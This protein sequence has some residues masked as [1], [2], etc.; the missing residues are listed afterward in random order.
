MSAHSFRMSVRFLS[1]W[2]IGSGDGIPG[3][4]DALVR[5]DPHDRLPFV[6][7][8]SL[9]GIWRDT[10]E[11]I[12]AGLDGA[13]EQGWRDFV[14][15]VFGRQSAPAA[16]P[17]RYVTSSDSRL[18][19]VPG[20]FSAPV[21][22]RLAGSQRLRDALFMVKP[23]VAIDP[24]TGSALGR[25]LRLVERVVSGT[26]FIAEGTLDLTD[27]SD[28]RGA[29]RFLGLAARRIERLG[30]DRRRGAGLCEVA[31]SF[32]DG[33]SGV[34]LPDAAPV[35]APG[36]RAVVANTAPTGGPVWFAL[37]LTLDLITPVSVP[38]A[39][40]GN[41][42][43]SRDMIDGSRLLPALHAPLAAVFGAARW[44]AAVVAGDV[45]CGAAYPSLDG[46]R[47][48]PLAVCLRADKDQREPFWCNALA[49][50][51][52]PG[53][54][55]RGGYGLPRGG[56]IAWA[57]IALQSWT[58]NTIDDDLQRPHEDVGGVYT[59]EAIPAGLRYAGMLRVRCEADERPML[60]Q[61]LC[62]A[63]SGLSL[64]LGASRNSDYGLV[65]I[66][67]AQETPL[68]AAAACSNV[69]VLVAASDLVLRDARDTPRADAATWYAALREAA[70]E[71]PVAWDDHVVAPSNLAELGRYVM[72]RRID[73]WNTRHR[74]PRT[75]LM[76][77]GAGSVLRVELK[78][79]LPQA[80]LDALAQAGLGERR[81]EG[82][83][84]L[85][86][87]PPWLDPGVATYAQELVTVDAAAAAVGEASRHDDNLLENLTKRAWRDWIAARAEECAFADGEFV[88]RELGWDTKDPDNAQLAAL[89]DH[90][91]SL[92][93]TADVARLRDWLAKLGRTKSRAAKWPDTARR[94]INV[95]A[96]GDADA[97][98]QVW[99]WL[100][101]D[102]TCVDAFAQETGVDAAA[103]RDHFFPFALQ[104]VMSA[105]AHRLHRAREANDMR[106]ESA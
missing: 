93:V 71:H 9:R 90:V 76:A 56:G 5:R 27:C 65:R 102:G 49:D 39:T 10:C 70:L 20:R 14:D 42:I 87:D 106:K 43:T 26:V 41:V 30:G 101:A 36:S 48:L 29:Q 73:G 12:A 23:G 24:S 2:S 99:T 86:V 38:D 63:L 28:V 55:L 98:A 78:K 82:Y 58:H 69:L 66:V 67:A 83:G 80:F 22:A 64:R 25:H 62:A 105:A 94:A 19:L 21:R 79:P 3:H 77:I 81:A 54:P 60:V 57:A 31:V 37:R 45:Q 40:L 74:A 97:V 47:A 44:S 46:Q 85:V 68:V 59:I 61:R 6:P 32:D 13:A 53:K 11:Q 18:R 8:K 52:A 17:E 50:A 33:A 51:P 100:D 4:I 104:C 35:F 84:E 72:P 1:D 15:A 96:R 89:L 16:R 75:T 7:A 92:R 88:K 34:P 103:M 95:L 91:R